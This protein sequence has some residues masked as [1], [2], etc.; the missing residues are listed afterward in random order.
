MMIL[1]LIFT[2]CQKKVGDDSL[3]DKI[4]IGTIRV[5]ND[6]LVAYQMGFFKDYFQDK[7]IDVQLLYFDSGTAANVA[8]ASGD[9]DFAGMGYTNAI[10]AL[11]NNINT[12]LIWI[13]EILGSNEAL[14]VQEDSDIQS[15]SD[16][17][18]KRVATP[19]S[20][21]SHYS[22]LNALELAGLS[23]QDI[24]LLDMDT[25]DIVAAWERKDI[26]AAY[27]WEP[28]LTVLKNSGCVLID[29]QE[30][31]DMGYITANIELVNKA[32]S[33]KYPELVADYI[34]ALNQAVEL[35][36]NDTDQAVEAAATY[37][38]VDQETIRKQMAGSQWVTAETQSTE[39]YLG[40]Q[41]APGNFH[42]IFLKTAE[43][44]Y[45]QQRI[46]QVPSKE[47]INDYINESYIE[48]SLE[49]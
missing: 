38:N 18:G 7:G 29:S 16:L 5:P 25:E 15:I 40:T 8:F 34:S 23:A 10:V 9:L 47:E 17:K 28:T 46:R 1:M 4:S 42:D 2:A 3:P 36:L 48:R 26:D 14:V 20:S 33:E 35:Y 13:H 12:E 37:L 19:F 44:L 27:S 39:N 11:S 32:F 30:L 22:L 6:K 31:A 43:F 49:D 24:Q 45:G 41:D 21:T